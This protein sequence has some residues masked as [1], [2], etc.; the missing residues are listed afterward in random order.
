MALAMP[1]FHLSELV[2]EV[3]DIGFSNLMKAKFLN[4]VNNSVN[5]GTHIPGEPV[6][7][8]HNG[9]T[10]N[11]NMPLYRYYISILI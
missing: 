9:S 1:S 10:Q 11:F 2:L 3:P 4:E 6:K 8:V 7:L 5:F